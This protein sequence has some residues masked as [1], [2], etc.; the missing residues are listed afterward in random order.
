MGMY[1]VP[2]GVSNPPQPVPQGTEL[3]EKGFGGQAPGTMVLVLV[4]LLAFVVYYFV[5]WKLLSVLW[6]IG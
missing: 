4:F 5:N 6:R 1:G 2:Q 3:E